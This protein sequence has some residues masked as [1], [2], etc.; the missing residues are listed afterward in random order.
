MV[1]V[2][3]FWLK[4]HLTWVELKKFTRFVQAKKHKKQG[5]LFTA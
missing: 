1:V 5:F 4:S 2:L 3:R